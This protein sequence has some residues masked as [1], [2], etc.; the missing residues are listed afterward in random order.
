MAVYAALG[1]V[2]ASFAFI[3]TY[4]LAY[5]LALLIYD[6]PQSPS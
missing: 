5:V 2:Q 3:L 6:M 1:V 4:S